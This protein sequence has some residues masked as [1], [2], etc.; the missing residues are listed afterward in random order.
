M[1]GERVSKAWACEFYRLRGKVFVDERIIRNTLNHMKPWNTSQYQ[2][3]TSFEQI[4][5][6]DKALNF[7]FEDIDLGAEEE[8]DLKEEEKLNEGRKVVSHFE[9]EPE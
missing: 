3:M 9:T 5:G 2:P 6:I 1:D 7:H 8:R 4:L